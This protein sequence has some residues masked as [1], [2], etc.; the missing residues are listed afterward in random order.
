MLKSRKHV[1]WEALII[2]IFVFM[3][4]FLFG[5]YMEQRNFNRL[6]DY[7]T[8]SEVTLI[9]GMALVQLSEKQNIDCSVL[10]KSNVEFANRVYEDAKLLEKYEESGKLTDSI[11]ILHKKYDVLRTLAWISNSNALERCNDYDLIVYLYEYD[12][13]NININSMQNVWSKKLGDYKKSNPDVV[14][15]PLAGNQDISSLEILKEKYGVQRLPAV[16]INNERVIYD[17]DD[18]DL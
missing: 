9:D 3:I 1:F 17:F 8:L 2:T 7:S 4:G 11:K 5:V 12:S 18:F 10:K 13:E 15:L 16:I 14:L 6:S